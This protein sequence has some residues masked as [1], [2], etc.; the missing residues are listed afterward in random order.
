MVLSVPPS[1]FVTEHTAQQ[2]LCI[3]KVIWTTL[4]IFIFVHS[5]L[6]EEKL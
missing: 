4:K 5:E 3:C 6:S 1:S 2:Q